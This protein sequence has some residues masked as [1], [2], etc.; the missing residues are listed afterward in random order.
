MLPMQ[1]I[2]KPPGNQHWDI[3][4]RVVDNFGDIGVCWRLARQLVS[5]HDL[6]VRLWVDDL[7]S[8]Q[9]L[10]PQID[11]ESPR[12]TMAGVDV[13]HWPASFPAADT[14]DVVIEAFACEL[15]ATYVAAMATRT[16]APCWINLEYLSAEPWVDGCH[17]LASPHP[18]L[19][20]VK[21]FFFP[22][23]TPR[24][25]G[26]LFEREAILTKQ[27][28]VPRTDPYPAL[29]ISLFCYETAPV[30][31]LVDAWAN[32]PLPLRCHVAA[33]KPQAAM[34]QV[35]GHPGPWQTGNLELCPLPFLP[36]ADYDQ[37][38]RRCA[39]NF[40]RGEDSFLRAQWAARPFVWNIYRQDE[41]AH[42][43]KLEAFVARY[44]EHLPA[45]TA[46][47]TRQMFFAWNTG[48]DLTMA[49]HHFAAQQ[50]RL[51]VHARQWAERLT[52]NG[53]LAGNLVKFCASMI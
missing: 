44:T 24:S 39:I 31:E 13:R 19:P 35:F 49:W 17:G 52:E 48:Q 22:G 4:C 43:E 1:P 16:P 9:A 50:E 21:Y 37:L 47:A 34:G 45:S 41:D 11:S 33:G 27:E 15:P 5:E 36:Q 6:A 53:D 14:A 46:L 2:S 40:V 7:A 20:L 51:K 3:F 29:E 38:L 8:L 30:K 25:G 28:N 12:Q 10:C 42:L 32:S 18:R 26:L 23:F